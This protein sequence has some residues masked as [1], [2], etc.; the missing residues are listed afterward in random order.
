MPTDRRFR[1]LVGAGL[2]LFASSGLQAASLETLVMPGPVSRAHAETEET[3]N[4]CHN[5][6][7]RGAQRTLCLECHEPIAED[8]AAGTGYHGRGDDASGSKCSSC[9][10]EHLGRDADIVG[11][12]PSLFD[13]E[14]TDFPLTGAHAAETCSS[15]HDSDTPFAEAPTACVFCHEADHVHRD[16][17]ALEGRMGAECADCHQTDTWQTGEFDHSSTD[18][19][20]TGGHIGP[21]CLGCHADQRFEAPESECVDCHRTDDVHNGTNGSACA[22]CHDTDSWGTSL[23][24]HARV[25]GFAL[26]D[27]HAMVQCRSCHVAPGEYQSPPTTCAGCHASDDVHLGRNGNDCASCH[28]QNDWA[29]S[30]DHLGETGYALLG[31]HEFADCDSCHTDGFERPLAIECSGCHQADDPHEGTLAECDACHGQD[32]W[33]ADQRFHHDLAGF[34]LVGLH[35]VAS[36]E[37]CH[38]SL[39]FSPLAQECSDCHT[40]DDHHEGAMGDQCA[41]CHNPAGWRYWSF[42]HGAATA[43][44]LSGAH[45]ELNCANCHPAG[46]KASRQ[47]RACVSCHRSEDVHDGGFGQNCERCHLTT[48]FEELKRDF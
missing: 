34:A 13:H 39:V 30:F 24:D 45:E 32:R 18:F 42:D 25:T 31:T 12:Q 36:C 6:F 9:H 14:L 21:S 29:R 43:F 47:S 2:L 17:S 48:T 10:T 44:E 1:R 33:G 27:A 3:C 8:L 38:D 37:Q 11:L 22:D 40:E 26:D 23:F 7:E 46:E 20:L 35:R 28:D 4:A 41:G 15:C 19:P 16:A 5:L